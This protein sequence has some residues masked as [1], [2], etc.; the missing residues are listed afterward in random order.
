MVGL[1][2][3][4]ENGVLPGF[5]GSR[6][7]RLAAVVSGDRKKRERLARKYGAAAAVSYED[8]DA[9]M[10]SGT[11]DA[12]YIALPNHLHRE[13]AERA[14]R[15]G[16]H[17]LCEKPLA[18]T[19]EDAE[20][21]VRR[22]AR[23][24]VKVMTAY[25]LHF[26]PASLDMLRLVRGKRIGE[27]CYLT[28]TFSFRATDADNVRFRADG[29]GAVADLGVYCINAARHLFGAEPIEVFA[30]VGNRGERRYLPVGETTAA[31]LRFPGGRLASFTVSLGAS[32]S[33]EYRLVGTRGSLRVDPG[34]VFTEPLRHFLKTG[35]RTREL[36]RRSTDHFRGEIE[37]FARMI[38][39]DAPAAAW[40]NEGLADVRVI[41][42]IARSVATGRPVKLT[43]RALGLKLGR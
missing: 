31:I 33:Y 32:N 27:L 24:R 8:Y 38:V 20:A 16:V 4:A 39:S 11:V 40:A 1:G 5:K 12:V 2:W 23:H 21:I 17:V 25:R 28:A 10:R 37:A 6:V 18:A 15:A 34:F 9:L 30:M 29:G 3:I 19:L 35:G 36:P 14:A 22:A 7:A 13:Y 42:A 41:A 26:E 43:P